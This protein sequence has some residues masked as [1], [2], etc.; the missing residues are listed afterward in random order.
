MLSITVVIVLTKFNNCNFHF[1]FRSMESI[2]SRLASPRY[3]STAFNQ[4]GG[5]ETYISGLIV[6]NHLYVLY[7]KRV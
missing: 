3:L 5:K 2:N 1:H 7:I 4:G 6:T